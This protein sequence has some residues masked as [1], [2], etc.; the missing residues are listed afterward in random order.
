MLH[1]KPEKGLGPKRCV[2]PDLPLGVLRRALRERRGGGEP[3][4]K[5]EG[6]DPPPGEAGHWGGV[7]SPR[8][9]SRTPTATTPGTSGRSTAAW[10][11]TRTFKRSAR[12][13]HEAG[14]RV[15][16][17]GVFNHVG[18][19]FWAFRDVQEKR[20]ASP[21]KDWFHINFR[22]QQR[23]Q[24]RLL[25]RGLGGPLRA[26]EAEPAKPRGGGLPAGLRG[27]LDGGVRHRRAAAGRG[28]PAGR[29]LYAAAAQLRA[30]R[31]TRASSS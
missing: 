23:L 29:E 16:L 21:Y 1:G 10:A 15:V 31:G 28:L 9:L 13:L 6:V 24:R 8:C 3:H 30:G 17:D 26:G 18:R 11:P 14:I 12:P 2:L 19:G 20:E 4:P 25:V 5:G 7:L 22:R 27:R